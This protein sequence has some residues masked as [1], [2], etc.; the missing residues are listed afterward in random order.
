MRHYEHS[1]IVVF[2]KRQTRKVAYRRPVKREN[3]KDDKKIFIDTDNSFSIN[4]VSKMRTE[5][6]KNIHS[7]S[8]VCFGR[9]KEIIRITDLPEYSTMTKETDRIDV[10]FDNNTGVPFYR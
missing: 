1:G 9:S 5:Y 3:R 10:M 8:F 6:E 4:A 2:R 7:D